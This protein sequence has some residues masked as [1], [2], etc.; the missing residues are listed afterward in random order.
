MAWEE[1]GQ[2]VYLEGGA[3]P[4]HSAGDHHSEGQS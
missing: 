3:V 1:Q 2:D 4:L